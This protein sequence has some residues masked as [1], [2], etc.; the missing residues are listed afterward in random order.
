MGCGL[1]EVNREQFHL[2]WKVAEGLLDLLWGPMKLLVT[3][4]SEAEATGGNV[5]VGRAFA[6]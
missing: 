6:L 1:L 3:G 5:G 4:D 2:A